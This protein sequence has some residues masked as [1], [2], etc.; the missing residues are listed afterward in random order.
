MDWSQHSIPDMRLEARFG[1][2]V[3]PAFCTRP[4]SI[5]AMIAE[6]AAGNPDG[7]A[8]VCG[9]RR[10]CWREVAQ[11]SAGIAAGFHKL[12]LRSGDR[13][14][15]LLGNR[16]EFAL[17]LFAAAHAGLVTVLLSTRQQK[18]EIAYVLTDCGARLLIHEA[19]LADRLPD[20]R[21]VP[22]LEH[23]IETMGMQDR[24][25]DIEI[26]MERVTEIKEGGKRETKDSKIFPGYVLVRMEMDDD[27]W[28]CVRNTPGV[29]GF[30][31]GNGKPAPLSRDEY[32][33]M[34][35]RP[36]KG[37]SPKRTSVD[38]EVGTSVRVTDGPLTD[39]DGKVSE[40]NP[41]AGKLKVTLMIF[42]RET[43]VELDFN[44]VAVIA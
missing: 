2:R 14:A 38:I 20:A 25:F 37:D 7:E 18:P 35:R 1:D 23:R 30:L 24:I 4:A 19:G 43:P 44:Q 26:P 40:V 21:D 22:D 11:Q 9:E 5:W 36:G 42:G 12:G 27:A 10:L 32:N 8:L 15:V 29:T 34:T 16:I 33:K 28:T 13:V 31:G 6:A 3:V 17:T 39:V 41:E